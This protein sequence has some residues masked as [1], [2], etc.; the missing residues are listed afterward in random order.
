MEQDSGVEVVRFLPSLS[1]TILIFVIA[2]AVSIDMLYASTTFPVC[3]YIIAGD[4]LKFENLSQGQL[5]QPIRVHL[6]TQTCLCVHIHLLM[7]RL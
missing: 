4:V 7:V 1:R 6:N 2:L 3:G 5:C